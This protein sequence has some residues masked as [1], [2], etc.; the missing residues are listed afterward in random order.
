MNL[1]LPEIPDWEMLR[2]YLGYLDEPAKT[3]AEDLHRRL[4]SVCS[5]KFTYREFAVERKGDGIYLYDEKFGG[6]DIA[7]HLDGCDSCVLLAV[8]LGAQTD[9]LLRT[10]E[11]SDMAAAVVCDTLASVL[12]EQLCDDVLCQL[13]EQYKGKYLTECYSPGYG[14]L[15][16]CTNKSAE[17]LLDMPRKIGVAV[18]DSYLLLP[19]KSIT[20]IIGISEKE[21]KGHLADCESCRLYDKCKLRREGKSCGNKYI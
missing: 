18:T 6:D 19:R 15:P 9:A 13:R 10:L 4:S 8:T 21:T 2:R 12:A 17:R 5:P 20:A 7:K 1:K 16:L 11:S 14:D 3:L